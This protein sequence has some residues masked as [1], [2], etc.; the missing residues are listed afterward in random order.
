M[1]KEDFV[2][3]MNDE[4]HAF[5]AHFYANSD[6]SFSVY[7]KK[8]EL[9]VFFTL[10]MKRYSNCNNSLEIDEVFESIRKFM[11][12]L[13]IGLHNLVIEINLSSLD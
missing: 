7:M 8:N 1:T 4:F 6:D 3:K 10:P 11:N 12:S 2:K 13:T 9:S 5:N